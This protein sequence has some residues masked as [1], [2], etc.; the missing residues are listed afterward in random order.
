MSD[1][2][3]TKKHTERFNDQI[4][5]EVLNDDLL[6]IKMCRVSHDTTREQLAEGALSPMKAPVIEDGDF[7]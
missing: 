7:F 4:R 3:I 1:C 2:N 6:D 5:E